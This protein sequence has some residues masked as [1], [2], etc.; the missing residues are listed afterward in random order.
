MVLGY[1][2]L[3]KFE[4]ARKSM[5]QLLSFAERFRMDNPLV[6]FGGA[7]YQPGEPIN[8]TYDAFGAPVSSQVGSGSYWYDGQQYDE[9]SGLIY[10]RARYYNPATG[11]FLNVDSLAGDGQ[12]G[13]HYDDRGP[14]CPDLRT[15]QPRG[16]RRGL[17]PT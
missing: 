11:R 10:L 7:V 9:T 2:R 5:R 12:R 13:R 3:G 16:H 15:N 17:G 1:Y 14:I 6:A 4:D 8:L